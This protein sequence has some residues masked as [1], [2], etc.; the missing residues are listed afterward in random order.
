MECLQI[1]IL[2]IILKLEG[3]QKCHLTH[4]S[5]CK[6]DTS[7]ICPGK[8][9]LMASSPSQSMCL[10][11][12]YVKLYVASLSRKIMFHGNFIYLKF[13]YLYSL[14]KHNDIFKLK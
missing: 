11:K 3:T 1:V 5:A 10:A 9:G 14:K 7:P 12:F 8:P 2:M 4:L 6:Q 13:F